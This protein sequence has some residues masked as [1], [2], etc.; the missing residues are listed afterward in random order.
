MLKRSCVRDFLSGLVGLALATLLFMSASAAKRARPRPEGTAGLAERFAIVTYVLTPDQE[1]KAEI[2]IKSLRRFGGDYGG[3]PVYVV[4]GNPR[5]VPCARLRQDG[6]ELVPTDASKLGQRY[7][8]AIKAYA[9]AQIE[10]LTADR[11]DTLAWFDPETM[12]VGPLTSLDLGEAFDAAV[13]PV[14]KLNKVALP[15]DAPPDAFWKPIFRETGLSVEEIPV[16]KS[17]LEGRPIKAYFNC[18]IFSV[19]PRI[20][21]FREWAARLEPFL[22]DQDYQWTAC[23]DLLHRLFLHQAVLSAVIISKTQATRRAELPDSCGYPLNLHQ[24]LPPARKAAALNGLSGVILETL[25][26]DNPDWMNL[27]EIREPLRSWLQ[28]AFSDYRMVMRV[29]RLSPF[30][31]L[32][33][34][35]H[36]TFNHRDFSLEKIRPPDLHRDVRD[37]AVT[38]DRLSVLNYFS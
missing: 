37:N 25:W 2:L 34:R 18:E 5:D 32:S 10:R 33:D 15:A 6:V 29:F 9:A 28:Q 26:D 11:F 4:L 23:P 24:D 30:G 1:G 13:K 12:V 38:L 22:K 14:F 27:L 36:R 31:H 16:V 19:R 20:G 8:L 17:I 35:S 3:V 7:P 21:I